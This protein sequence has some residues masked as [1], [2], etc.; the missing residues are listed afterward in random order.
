M[1]LIKIIEFDHYPEFQ[2]IGYIKEI[3]IR[4]Q[5]LSRGTQSTNILPIHQIRD[6]IHQILPIL[7]ILPIP[8]QFALL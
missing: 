2:T 5:L 4:K 7:Q 8:I 3:D 1:I 6:P